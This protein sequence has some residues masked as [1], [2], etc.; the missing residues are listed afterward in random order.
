MNDDVELQVKKQKHILA[1]KSIAEATCW[2][3]DL[4]HLVA[5]AAES[6]TSNTEVS[7][8]PDPSQVVSAMGVRT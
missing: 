5:Q 4:V 6:G 8:A 7:A 2:A 3:E 1:S